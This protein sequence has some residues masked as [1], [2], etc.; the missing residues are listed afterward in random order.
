MDMDPTI[1][2][3]HTEYVSRYNLLLSVHDNPGSYMFGP[4]CFERVSDVK[5]ESLVS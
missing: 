5:P 2:L 3:D 4:G 1:R